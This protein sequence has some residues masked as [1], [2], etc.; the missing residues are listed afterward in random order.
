VK[1]PRMTVLD[2][3]DVSDNRVHTTM[4]VG[5]NFACWWSGT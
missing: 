4:T 5:V 2:T 1:T 3:P